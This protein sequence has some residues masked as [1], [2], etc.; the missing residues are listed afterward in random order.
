MSPQI[1]DEDVE[2][3]IAFVEYAAM[4]NAYARLLDRVRTRDGSLT[5]EDAHLLYYVIK[6]VKEHTHSMCSKH[7]EL[8]LVMPW[9]QMA[10]EYDPQ[11]E[12]SI[13]QFRSALENRGM[14]D[15]DID[16]M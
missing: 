7:R 4:L 6:T 10:F 3:H 11:L 9:L 2:G 1:N 14:M 15:F 13:D 5:I 16:H 12:K 8:D